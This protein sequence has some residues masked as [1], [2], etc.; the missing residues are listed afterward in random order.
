MVEGVEFK[1]LGDQAIL[2]TVQTWIGLDAM[3]RI[4]I[5]IVV[6][7]LGFGVWSGGVAPDLGRLVVARSRAW[8]IGAGKFSWIRCRWVFWSQRCRGMQSMLRS[9]RVVSWRGAA[10][11]SCR[12]T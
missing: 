4:L 10:V 8:R 5:W 3:P 9:R 12:R 2:V 7:L 1:G 11:G 6:W